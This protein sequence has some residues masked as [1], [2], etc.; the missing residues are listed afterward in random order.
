MSSPTCFSEYDKAGKISYSTKK[1]KA[2]RATSFS[3][4]IDSSIQYVDMDYEVD[5]SG[6]DGDDD[7]RQDSTCQNSSIHL[8]PAVVNKSH[9]IDSNEKFKSTTTNFNYSAPDPHKR[10]V[11][12]A[13]VF[14]DKLNPV[15]G[16]NKDLLFQYVLEHEP[17]RLKQRS[18]PS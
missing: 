5:F 16:F 17:D 6:Y 1:I 4:K 8:P 11:L 9:A 14:P 2:K 18:Q 13:M 15:L 3:V 12:D 7:N 10:T